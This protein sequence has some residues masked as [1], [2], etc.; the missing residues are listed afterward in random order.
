[1]I[2]AHRK[3][4]TPTMRRSSRV[5]LNDL[6]FAKQQQVIDFLRLCHD[7]TQ[8]FVDVFWARQDF[9]A[10]LADLPTVHLATKRFGITTRLSQAL[11]KQA[12][13]VVRSAHANHGSKPNIRRH[14]V[15]LYRHFVKVMPF[16]GHFD[17]AVNLIGSGAPRL[18]LPVHSTQHLNHKLEDGWALSKTI[19]LGQRQG[20]IFVDF[21]LEKPAPALKRA[22]RVVGMDSNYKNGLVLSDGQT[23]GKEAYNTIQTFSKRQ[24]RTRAQ[25]KSLVFAAIR[26]IDLSGI[27]VLVI[28]DLKN[29]RCHTRGKF[30]RTLNR[31]LSHWLYGAYATRL[32]QRCE[33]EGVQLQRKDP[34]KTSQRCY[35]CGKWDRRNRRG[36]RFV[37]VNCG[38]SDHADF[39][40]SKNLEFLG[41]AGIYGF[42]SLPNSCQ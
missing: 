9:S 24:K 19:R 8:Y 23:T 20:R 26:K 11:A 25:I 31:R 21:L 28:E 12:K 4:A 14:V 40:S 6:N 16:T 33:E 13:E 5:Y 38:H 41:L 18:T 37:C 34:W 35:P 3:F 2:K 10:K 39:N 36:D 1:M 30:P 17:W 7:V 42:R 15:T 27:R 32:E 29:V 22:G